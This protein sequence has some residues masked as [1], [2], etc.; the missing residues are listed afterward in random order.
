SLSYIYI[1]YA[2]TVK[3]YSAMLL[4]TTIATVTY[5]DIVR[6][7]Q[8]DRRAAVTLTASCLALAYLNHFAM[9]YAAMLI[10]LLC[11][12]FHADAD[13]RRRTLRVAA[14][15]GLGYVPIAYFLYIQLRYD[16]DA[17]QPYQV[18]AFLANLGPS[19]F[20]DDSRFLAWALFGLAAAA[21][22]RVALDPSARDRLW[23]PRTRHLLT[24]VALFGGFMLALGA[25]KPIF[26]VRYFLTLAPAAMLALSIVAATAFPI[27]RGWL[28]VLPLVFFAHG[29]LVQYRSI[30]GL[31]REQWDKSVDY[32]LASHAPA[33]A[34]FVLG[35]NPDRTEF[36][37]LK[38]GDVDGVF[39]VRNLRFYRYYFR[40]RGAMDI[41][42][43]LK[44]I[45]PSVE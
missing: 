6:A 3:Q 17:W 37:Y 31:Q 10:G 2:L 34:I 23:S 44:E 35:A 20:F 39:N 11:L 28:A 42:D 36:D 12:T 1:F 14:A 40:R 13:M 41:A 45:D 21:I 33:D 7:R 30:D 25:F 27:E 9:V 15:Y 38:M 19:F 18:P 29:A 24:I 4:F 43:A 26:Y 22:V 8:M 5:L 32:V 16:I